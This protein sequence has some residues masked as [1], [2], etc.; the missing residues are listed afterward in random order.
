MCRYDCLG[1]G[2]D[3]RVEEML[4][5]LAEFSLEDPVHIV[6]GSYANTESMEILGFAHDSRE[7]RYQWSLLLPDGQPITHLTSEGHI[8]GRCSANAT[9][10]HHKMKEFE[11][12]TGIYRFVYSESDGLCVA[13]LLMPTDIVSEFF[14]GGLRAERDEDEARMHEF[15]T[16]GAAD[17]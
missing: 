15:L 11:E 14:G 3:M 5:V 10:Y 7:H 8:C 1:K 2:R 16:K 9:G 13:T 4:D 12:A 17:C 6:G